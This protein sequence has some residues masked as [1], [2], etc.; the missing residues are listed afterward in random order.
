MPRL[1]AARDVVLARSHIVVIRT[2]RF[3]SAGSDANR[4]VVSFEMRSR[5]LLEAR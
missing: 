2:A 4:S 5:Q 1:L 3:E